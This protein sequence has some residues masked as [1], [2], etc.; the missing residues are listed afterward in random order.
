MLFVI[1][2]L[3]PFAII[4][5]MNSAISQASEE[6]RGWPVTNA[7]AETVFFLVVILTIYISRNK[8]K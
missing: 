7:I 4:V 6:N 8:K 3:L 5:N 2:A 1:S